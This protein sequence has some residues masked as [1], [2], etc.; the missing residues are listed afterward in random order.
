MVKEN[1]NKWEDYL[2][3]VLFAYRTSKQASTK[4][5]PFFLLYGREPRLPMDQITEVCYV[6]TQQ[7]DKKKRAMIVWP[8]F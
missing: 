4:F 3:S 1:E 5:S 8:H 2:D 6:I 7:I